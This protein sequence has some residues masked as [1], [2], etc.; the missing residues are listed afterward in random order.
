VERVLRRLE[1]FRHKT[2]NEA[3]IA[4]GRRPLSPR[5]LRAIF[6]KTAEYRQDPDHQELMPHVDET[7]VAAH[8]SGIPVYALSNGW[9]PLQE[10]KIQLI[11]RIIQ[12]RYGIPFRFAGRRFSSHKGDHAILDLT[13]AIVDGAPAHFS[14]A[15]P[16]PVGLTELIAGK[17]LRS[18]HVDM[19][20]D[21][22]VADAG[23]AAIAQA[24]DIRVRVHDGSGERWQ[25][26]RISATFYDTS[27]HGRSEAE[28]EQTLIE[29]LTD[30]RCDT[31]GK[32]FF[33]ASKPPH[34]RGKR[35]RD[36]LR[37]V[38]RRSRTE[39]ATSEM[40]RLAGHWARA[41][42][43]H[44]ELRIIRDHRNYGRNIPGWE[45]HRP[46]GAYEVPTEVE[47]PAFRQRR[48]RTRTADPIR[49]TPHIT[50]ELHTEQQHTETNRPVSRSK[51]HQ[52]L[53]DAGLPV[54]RG[55][56]RIGDDILVQDRAHPR[57]SEFHVTQ[58]HHAWIADHVAHFLAAQFR[59]DPAELFHDGR[60][61]P[62]VALTSGSP[63]PNTGQRAFQRQTLR[64]LRRIAA[65]PAIGM[66]LAGSGF[67]NDLARRLAAIAAGVTPA[68]LTI[69]QDH[70]GYEQMLTVP[71]DDTSESPRLIGTAA[72]LQFE[73]SATSHIGHPLEQIAGVLLDCPELRGTGGEL[74]E[75][76][77][78]LLPL[79]RELDNGEALRSDLHG[80]M[81][82]VAIARVVD[83]A[84]ACL[85]SA[86]RD[87]GNLHHVLKVAA[88]QF[89]NT[90]PMREHVVD[91][92]GDFRETARSGPLS[93][94]HL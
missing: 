41:H 26:A 87:A 23:V 73:V 45:S 55:L 7:I 33:E 94:V 2:L 66:L 39:P 32:H 30:Y 16:S 76:V 85:A 10:A 35:L 80:V 71:G 52:M 11:E 14:E 56:M 53:F 47:A 92:L 22:P 19:V 74:P 79:Y 63:R 9:R 49:R 44:L 62:Y 90:P 68:P 46:E 64:Y 67:D 54:P 48:S 91:W 21:N 1:R 59:L 78:R 70:F 60:P 38:R 89:G 24:E 83:E 8:L 15:K 75:F 3:L 17:K 36:A 82:V 29:L 72:H 69:V 58:A 84:T 81:D 42:V 37:F 43:Q 12:R 51:L 61:R 40:R 18:A 5:E 27:E 93:H 28:I 34:T 25:R 86:N 77:K 6:E 57:V 20:G 50:S 65:S 13:L 31:F 4:S 88:L